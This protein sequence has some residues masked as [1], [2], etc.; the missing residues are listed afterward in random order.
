MATP[1][2]PDVAQFTV[3]VRNVM[4]IPAAYLPDGSPSIQHAYDQ[5][6]NIVNLALSIA[7]SQ[8]LSWS[9]YELA[10]YNLAGHMLCEYGQDPSYP[11]SA[12]TWAQG[13]AR[14]VTTAAT[15]I[16]PGNK[17][18][19]TGVS[20][21]GYSGPLN[22][23]YITVTATPDTTHF[24]Y[25]IRENPG[26]ATIL[27]GASV[28]GTLFAQLRKQFKMN[29]FMPG[30]VASASDVSTS[31]GLDNPDFLKGLTLF[32][33]QLLKTP[34]GRAYLSIAQKVGPTAF[35]VS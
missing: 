13:Y 31:V 1:G 27:S 28:N 5:S 14:A 15:P 17:M 7:A 9:P 3:W 12:V 2:G 35:G 11:L 21:L 4:G 10:V 8:R 24:W 22:I 23:G 16:I 30:V 25:P 32:D 18:T 33:L 34:W 20:P 29:A 19:I 26:P 6:L